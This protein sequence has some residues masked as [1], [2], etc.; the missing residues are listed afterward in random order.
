MMS[1]GTTGRA[2]LLNRLPLRQRFAIPYDLLPWARIDGDAPHPQRLSAWSSEL[3]AEPETAF[4]G[5]DAD[6]RPVE[7]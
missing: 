7:P 6:G 3:D 4:P 1:F 5:W 2:V